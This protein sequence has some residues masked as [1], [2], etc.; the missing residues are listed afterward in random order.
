MKKRWM[1]LFS[2]PLRHLLLQVLFVSGRSLTDCAFGR[3]YI[4]YF[5]MF[6]S[7]LSIGDFS[8]C[9]SFSMASSSSFSLMRLL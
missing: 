7:H 8:L 1:S 4:F 5:N 2:H 6:S 3:P 9:F